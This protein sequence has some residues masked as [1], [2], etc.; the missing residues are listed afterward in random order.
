[1]DTAGAALAT[2]FAQAISVIFALVLLKKRGLH[3]KMSKKDFRIN[4]QY[5]LSFKIG[6]PFALQ[7]CLI[8]IS[9]LALCAF[10]NKM[11]I[12]ASS[13]Y[14]VANKIVS[15]AMLILGALMQSMA[16]F[17]SQNI[18]AGNEKRASKSMFTGIGIDVAIGVFVFALIP[19]KGEALVFLFTSAQAVIAHCFDYLKGFSPGTIVTAILFSMIGYFNESIHTVWVMIQGLVQTLLVRLP[20]SYFMSIQPDANLTRIGLAATVAMVVG[21]LLN[22]GYYLCL[23]K[24]TSSSI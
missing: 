8:Q 15:F 4:S 7:E 1:M 19:I 5:R 22:V 21:L 2:V 20:L 9:F 18:G 24:R 16:S 13:G 12:E 3:F 10:I 6:L 23:K 17:V 11:G 14:G